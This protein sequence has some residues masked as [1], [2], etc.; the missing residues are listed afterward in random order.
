MLKQIINDIFIFKKAELATKKDFQAA[1]DLQDT[2]RANAD[3]CVGMEFYN[4]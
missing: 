2:L 3:I 1:T 4:M